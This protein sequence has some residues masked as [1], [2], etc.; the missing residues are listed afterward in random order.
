MTPHQELKSVR[1]RLIQE[2]A[3]QRERAAWHGDRLHRIAPTA[4]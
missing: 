1:V 3:S 4:E 2:Q